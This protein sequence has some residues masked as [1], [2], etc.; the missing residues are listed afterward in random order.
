MRRLCFVVVALISCSACVVGDTVSAQRTP[1]ALEPSFAPAA[2]APDQ[3]GSSG[4]TV[5]PAETS[6]SPSPTEAVASATPTASTQ[7]RPTLP[8]DPGPTPSTADEEPASITI[9]DAVG[10][11]TPSLEEPP[12]YA[13]LAGATLTRAG[14]ALTLVVRMDGGTPE[15]SGDSDHTMNVAAFFDVDGD[16]RIDREVWANLADGGWDTGY[17]DNVN[18]RTAFS[19]DD[20]IDVAV[21]RG[22]LVLRFPVTAV[23]ATTFRWS[24]AS[25]WGRY[26]L[27]GTR[28]AARDDLPDDDRPAPSP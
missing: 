4:P 5:P 10:D 19:D 13:D 24:L 3:A 1:A 16:G 26:E 11:L 12:R 2:S 14:D 22:E 8:S 25:E 18:G 6:R 15:A 9:T 21:V 23:G 20:P 17:Y 28:A 7:P 27:I